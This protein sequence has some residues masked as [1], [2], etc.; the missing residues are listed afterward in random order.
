M[1]N[2]IDASTQKF[3][4][5]LSAVQARAER[6][7]RQ[8]SSGLRVTVASDAPDQISQLLQVRVDLQHN[9]QVS[10]NLGLV[11]AEVDTAEQ[12]LNSATTLMD[13]I[14]VIGTQG[15]TGTQPA[16]ANRILGDQVSALLE[17]LVSIGN[18]AVNGRHIFSGDSDQTN[19]YSLDATQPNGVSAYGGSAA[20]RQ[21]QHPSGTSF[22][23]AKTAKEIFDD[24]SAQKSV[25]GSVNALQIALTNNDT[26]GIR[27]AVGNLGTAADF[28]NSKLAFY[29]TVQNQVQA[30]TDFAAKQDLQLRSELSNLQDADV[31]EAITELT[32]AKFTQQAAMQARAS[33][34]KT[35]LFDYLFR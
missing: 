1:T 22:Q 11:K 10:S 8:L 24:P 7:Q 16:S 32:Q 20:T 21:A 17:R 26:A 15:A 13:Q 3:L 4:T 25:F 2:G 34:P 18:T 12:A 27:T 19:A 14:K 31:T 6:A 5:D 33:V 23:I 28:L 29:G 35:S 30:A 9:T